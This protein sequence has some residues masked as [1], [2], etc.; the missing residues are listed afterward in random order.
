MDTVTGLIRALRS[1]SGG[2]ILVSHDRH[3]VRCVIEGA[4]ILP[5]SEL[6]EDDDTSDTE[7]AEEESSRTGQ[8]FMVGPKGRVKLLPGGVDDVSVHSNL[9][10]TTLWC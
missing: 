9:L 7:E 2:I 3:L 8:V 1:F 6:V 4:P 10:C 5:P